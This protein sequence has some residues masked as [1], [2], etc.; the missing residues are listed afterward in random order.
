[1]SDKALY[2]EEKLFQA[3]NSLV[4]SDAMLRKRLAAA[5]LQLMPLNTTFFPDRDTAIAFEGI[6]E[7]LTIMDAGPGDSGKIDATTKRLSDYDA[8]RIAM[9]IFDLYLKIKDMNR[10]E[11]P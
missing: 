4:T 2:A 7:D 10:D 5:A 11:T 9:R 3:M 8:D 6:R 1:M